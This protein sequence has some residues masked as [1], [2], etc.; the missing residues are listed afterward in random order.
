MVASLSAAAI[1]D[2]PFAFAVVAGV[3]VGAVVLG[4][5]LQ[6]ARSAHEAAKSIGFVRALI[7]TLL[8]LAAIPAIQA[9]AEIVIA[10]AT[11]PTFVERQIGFSSSLVEIHGLALLPP[12]PA[13]A[14]LDPE[15]G[16]PAPGTY[17][18]F[19]LRD[20]LSDRRIALVRSELDGTALRATRDRGPQSSPASTT[21][22]SCPPYGRAASRLPRRWRVRRCRPSMRRPPPMPAESSPSVRWQSWTGCRPAAWCALTLDFG[23]DAVAGCVLSGN[24]DARRLAAG[25]GPWLHLAHDPTS[26]APVVV[27]LSYPPTVAPMHVYGRQGSDDGAVGRFLDG[28]QVRQLLGWAQVLRGAI[29]DHDPDLP[30]DRL[31]VGPILFVALAALLALGAWSGYPVFRATPLAA[32]PWTATGQGTAGQPPAAG[33]LIALGSG[34]IAP[35]GRSPIDLDEV[36]VTLS[37]SGDETVLTLV[38]REP[39]LAVTIPRALGAL[40]GME[41]GE[42]RYLLDGVPA[43]RVGWYGSQVLLVFETRQ[44]ARRRQPSSPASADGLLAR[45]LAPPWRPPPAPCWS[46][47]PTESSPSSTRRTILPTGCCQPNRGR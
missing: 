43:L 41:A 25:V 46:V 39:P 44:S 15:S 31:W 40:S 38:D 32:R 13:E 35:P 9:A 36:P 21:H 6:I 7:W 29:I 22:R 34:Y 10:R 8:V 20:E 26:G 1:V 2:A 3:L 4:W 18:W 23:G 42:L 30:V 47:V 45:T 17:R 16:V 19:P 5:R 12:F 33:S 14:P 28:P 27:Q 24:C 37:M 11:V